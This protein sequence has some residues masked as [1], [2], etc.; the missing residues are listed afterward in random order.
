[1]TDYC[2]YCGDVAS[3]ID[4]VPAKSRRWEL[5]GVVDFTTVPACKDCNCWILKARDG[6]DTV[7]QRREYVGKRLLGRLQQLPE[8]PSREMAQL[9]P[10]LK[11]K[12]ERL[13]ARQHLLRERLR[14]A[15]PSLYAEYEAQE[16]R[17]DAYENFIEDQIPTRTGVRI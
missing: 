15:S 17:Q 10:T 13:V 11:R 1:M 6:L 3:T 2:E 16:Q 14:I 4:H 7:A 9:G 12:I 5:K 8:W